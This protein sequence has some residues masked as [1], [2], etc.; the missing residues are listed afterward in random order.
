MSAIQYITKKD[1]E[2]LRVS[3]LAD[4]RK[5]SFHSKAFQQT[6]NHDLMQCD[7]DYNIT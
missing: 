7:C 5:A 3:E 1:I 2:I 6:R 4:T